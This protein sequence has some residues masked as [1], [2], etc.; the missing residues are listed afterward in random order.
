M[1]T[2]SNTVA[3]QSTFSGIVSRVRGIIES[4]NSAGKVAGDPAL[5][6]ELLLLV[7][8]SF[9]DRKID[10]EEADAFRSICTR[11]LGLHADELGD[12]MRFIE[13]FGYETT[14][15]QAADMLAD[16]PEER[17]REIMEHLA[18]MARADGEVDE[19]EKALFDRTARRLGLR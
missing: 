11:I 16:L 18:A 15:E 14:N 10:P 2:G 13:D 1:E 17:R 5:M 4:G 8:M 12:V 7:R 19:R 9:A 3:E 6:A